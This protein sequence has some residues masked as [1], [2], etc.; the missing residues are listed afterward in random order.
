MTASTVTLTARDGGTF[1]AY[2]AV[3][4]APNGGAV[5]IL[6]EIFGINANIRGIADDFAAAGYHAIAPDLFWRQEPGV[7]LN[8]ASEADRERATVLLK[9]TDQSLA[10]ED[11]LVAAAY[12]R[13]L[14]AVTG[15]V[16]AVGYCLGGKLAYML[17]TR[18]GIDAAVSYYGVAIQAALG[19]AANVRSKLLLHIAEEDHLCPP[20]AQE[21]IAEAMAAYPE[22][23]QI[24]RYPGVG[25]AFARRGGASFDAASAERADA[26]TMALLAEELQEKK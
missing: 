16:G 19:E 24:M 7:E 23:I 8:P 17:A 12:L 25:H 10:V 3:P 2:L 22:R 15:K 5:V 4:D 13:D 21:A 18:E 6:Q 26:A 1:T 20:E 11:A 14:P 9:G